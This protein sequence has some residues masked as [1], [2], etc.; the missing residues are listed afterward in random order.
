MSTRYSVNFINNSSNSG[1]VFIFQQDPD[2]QK[3][4][5]QGSDIMSLAWFSKT[6]HPNTKIKFTWSLDYSFVWSETGVLKPGIMFDASQVE[7]ADLTTNNETTFSYD[8]G[9]YEFTDLR[10]GTP[11][12]LIITEAGN[13]PSKMASVGIGMS[14][15]GT[16]VKQAQPNLTLIFTPHPKYY[17]AFGNQEQGEVLDITEINN[18][19]LLD[20]PPNVYSLTATLNVDNTWTIQPT[21]MSNELLLRSK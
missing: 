6:A 16:F 3:P 7:A 14:G 19:G 1:K 17:I 11:G 18:P 21:M 20:F 12:S 13:V 5:N 4:D 8:D 9:A 2:M 10:S 15:S